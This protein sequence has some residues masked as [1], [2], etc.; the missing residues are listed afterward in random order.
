M[1]T[2]KSDKKQVKIEQVKVKALIPYAGNAKIHTKDQIEKIAKS[3]EEFGFNNPVLIDDAGGII[4]GHGRVEAAKQ[5]SLPQV[6]CIRLSHLTDEQK[7]AYILADNKLSE[8][9][10]GW[11]EDLLADELLKL[12][13]SLIDLTGFSLS[14]S[15]KEA[16][17]LA[18]DISKEIEYVEE[19]NESE[20]M[21]DIIKKRVDALR[22]KDPSAL[23]KS[24]C[25]I[26]SQSST[27]ALVIV[28]PSLKDFVLEIQRYVSQGID[29][30][31]KAILNEA[32]KI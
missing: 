24:K 8:I 3:I 28:D 12:G 9:G 6:P 17:E 7:R 16:G 22:K 5:L 20:D 4:A 23:S 32:H 25:I 2:I 11:D 27:D 26:I 21:V 13:D 1:T 14:D 18:G 30:P 31:L 10:G 29:S 15:I 19:Y